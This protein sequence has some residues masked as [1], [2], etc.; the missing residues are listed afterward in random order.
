VNMT[1]AERAEARAARKYARRLTAY[2]AAKMLKC[3]MCG[4]MSALGRAQ[5]WGET[6]AR[7]CRYCGHWEKRS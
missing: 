7:K 1:T 3:P 5:A 6:V 2:E 4:R